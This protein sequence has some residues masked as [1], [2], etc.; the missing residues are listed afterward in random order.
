MLYGKSTSQSTLQVSL[1]SAYIK[2]IALVPGK[3][4]QGTHVWE[5]KLERYRFD[6]SF[7]VE[8]CYDLSEVLEITGKRNIALFAVCKKPGRN[9]F[10]AKI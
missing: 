3:G 1:V 8:Y 4:T 5:E 6:F 7:F 2:M 10:A 9:F